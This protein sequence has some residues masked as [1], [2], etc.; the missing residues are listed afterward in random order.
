M[1]TW[2][3]DFDLLYKIYKLN[4]N[5]L[6]FTMAKVIIGKLRFVLKFLPNVYPKVC[7]W[8][9]VSHVD[10]STS[11]CPE[12]CFPMISEQSIR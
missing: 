12:C 9:H 10:K 6:E 7:S 3:I 1:N 8:G 2:K 11:Q 4:R 5:I